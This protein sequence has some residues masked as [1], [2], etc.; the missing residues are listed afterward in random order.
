METMLNTAPSKAYLIENRP[1][2][3]SK[4]AIVGASLSGLVTAVTL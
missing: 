4:A 1:Y 2:G 3:L